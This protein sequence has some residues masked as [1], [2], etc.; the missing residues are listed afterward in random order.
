[1][2]IFGAGIGVFVY[3]SGNYK[4]AD[5]LNIMYI[6]NLAEFPFLSPHLL[7]HVSVFSGIMLPAQVFMGIREAWHLEASL[8]R[9]PSLCVKNC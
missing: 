9:L 3:V 7:E 8:H 5:Y 4:F 1:M 6:P 2:R